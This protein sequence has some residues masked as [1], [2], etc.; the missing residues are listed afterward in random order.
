MHRDIDLHLIEGVGGIHTFIDFAS[1]DLD[2]SV[3]T[4]FKKNESGQ[5]EIISSEKISR[6]ILSQQQKQIIIKNNEKSLRCNL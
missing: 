5:V 2:F 1:H 3:V 6:G 4:V